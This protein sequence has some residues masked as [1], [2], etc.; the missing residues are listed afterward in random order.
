MSVSAIS[1]KQI[2]NIFIGDEEAD[3]R[4]KELEVFLKCSKNNIGFV[5]NNSQISYQINAN[6]SKEMVEKIM[7]DV[8]KRIT[9]G[10]M[11]VDGTD[12]NWSNGNMGSRW[13]DIFNKEKYGAGFIR[14]AFYSKK[15]SAKWNIAKPFAIRVLINE[16]Y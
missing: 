15:H 9:S 7:D 16:E 12:G 5:L 4:Q 6:V 3:N 10:T 13:F 14:V 8:L 1:T 11:T 2:K